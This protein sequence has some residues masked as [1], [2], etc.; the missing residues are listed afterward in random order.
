MA[1]PVVAMAQP[2]QLWEFNDPAGT[3]L[4]NAVNTGTPGTA[5]WSADFGTSTTDGN[6][7]FIVNDASGNAF[8]TAPMG[9]DGG[10]ITYEI[11]YS[12]WD[13]DEQNDP[14]PQ[15]FRF[16]GVRLRDATAA[17]NVM[18]FQ[19]AQAGSGT[20][21]FRISDNNGVTNQEVAG[22]TD[23]PLVSQTVYTVKLILDTA[24][25]AYTVNINGADAASGTAVVGDL[26]TLNFYKQGT[27][28]GGATPDFVAID[29]IS[30]SGPAAAVGWAG[31]PVDELGWVDTL[32][33][34]GYVNVLA[35]DWIWSASLNNW[36]Y[37]PESI[38]T[39]SGSWTYV[40]GQ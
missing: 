3:L 32:T 16:L 35:G 21:R 5:S 4:E 2:V 29:S 1:F 27:F 9:T 37:M 17:S 36:M 22:Y 20:L 15:S 40:I 6:G 7:K 24:T 14:N 39:E 33:W 19:L 25:G 34:M 13:L 10:V 11:V 23:L 12:G 38:I 8:K 28:G 18:I 30:L 26:D 31:Y